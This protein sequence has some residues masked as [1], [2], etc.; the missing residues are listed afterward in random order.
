[1]GSVLGPLLFIIYIND[2]V[3]I[4]SDNIVS[5]YF[6][7]D[8]KLYNEKITGDDIDEMQNALDLLAECA[9]TWQLRVSFN[10]CCTFDLG[11]ARHIDEFCEYI[12]VGTVGLLE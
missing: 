8:A 5:K 6:A 7:D 9:D 1:Q 3:D 4:F 2:I 10:R 12:L 11:P